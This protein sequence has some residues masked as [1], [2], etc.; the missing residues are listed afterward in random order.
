MNDTKAFK[1]GYGVKYRY[2]TL[3]MCLAAFFICAVY[4]G[5]LATKT[6]PPTEGWY[7][8]Y[9]YI[10]NEEGAV[11]YLD[12]ELLFPPL[13]TYIIALFTRIFGYGILALRILGVAVFA[14]TGVF[15]S[16]IYEKLTHNRVLGLIGGVMTVAVLQS[17]VVQVFYDYIRF[18]DL[19]VYASVYFFLC[20]LDRV[21]LEKGGKPSFDKSVVLGTVFAVLAS[22]F[23]Q[24]SG[25]V[26]LIYCFI[27]FI[28]LAICLPY[29]KELFA[30]GG[31]IL[32]VTAA[33]YG[34]ML[35]FLWTQGSVGEY[36]RYNFVSSIDAKGGGNFLSLLF[37]WLVR[38]VQQLKGA[39]MI[40]LTVAG[41]L[42]IGA[43][44]ALLWISAK[45]SRSCPEQREGF[46]PRFERIF[47]SVIISVLFL[48]VTVPFAW[49]GFARVASRL[50]SSITAAIMFVF[51]TLFFAVA[52]FA[53]I[54]RK[55][56]RHLDWQRHYKY[57]FLSG[58]VFVLGFS[59]GT[60]GG[61]AESQVALGYAFVLLLIVAAARYRKKEIT[62]GIV[63]AA[64]LLLTCSAF[65]RKVNS[66]YL[67][68]GL[69]AGRYATQTESCDVPIL[70]GIKMSPEYA[71]MYDN[72]YR[73]V[74][75][76]TEKGE[77]IFVFPHMPVMYLATDRPKATVTAVQWF[78][79]S[80]DAAVVN[81][82]EIIKQ[83]KPA[84]MVLCSVGDSVI[85][86][87]EA[88]FRAG[89]RSGLGIMQDFLFEFVDDEGY[90]CLSQ[91]RISDGYTV[92][93]WLRP[94]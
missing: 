32:G 81:D 82:I 1:P 45:R 56:I 28:F 57:L 16:L 17:E 64:M 88:S 2:G 70:K 33:L 77:E 85:E 35:I 52:S 68:W 27:F 58:T 55:K 94:N 65:A 40:I 19:C 12:F 62:A 63:C 30:Q 79:V 8:Y 93:V 66:T 92:S 18:M 89:E 53:V 73:G 74:T 39:R 23:K 67:W 90:V 26:F 86:A 46:E 48:S 84:V 22:M 24:S 36:L 59:V 83:K 72:V 43:F 71:K 87:H 54:F 69:D 38:Y 13:Y 42:A 15:A 31:V 50:T 3:Y 91:D 47:K 34:A 44:A 75:E 49:A 61:L 20:Y 4:A 5:L 78:D 10:M 37:G 29:K 51:C 14:L 6:F 9:A 80:T 76:N 11:P 60:S 41:V 25:L 21:R 7:S